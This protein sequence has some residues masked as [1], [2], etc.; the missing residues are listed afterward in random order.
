[1]MIMSQRIISQRLKLNS[2]DPDSIKKMLILF[3]L[4]IAPL[5]LLLPSINVDRIYNKLTQSN[6]SDH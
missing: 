1:M 2:I 3:Q 5:V 6:S 4:N